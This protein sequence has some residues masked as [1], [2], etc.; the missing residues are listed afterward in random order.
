MSYAVQQG[1][2]D[3]IVVKG[4]I[5]VWCPYPSFPFFVT[6]VCDVRLCVISCDIN[7][8]HPMI[9]GTVVSY[10]SHIHRPLHG[11]HT[12]L[13]RTVFKASN[14]KISLTGLQ[15]QTRNCSVSLMR[16]L[17]LI[18]ST[19]TG[20]L[21]ILRFIIRILLRAVTMY[22]E[23]AAIAFKEAVDGKV[24]E[25]SSVTELQTDIK[26]HPVSPPLPPTPPPLGKII[27]HC[28]RHGFVRPLSNSEVNSP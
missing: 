1:L 3:A 7:H 11:S 19:L 13:S 22:L 26:A 20:F 23:T 8:L 17:T 14:S 2:I 9:A 12:P 25:A 28:I 10:R 18:T 15:K 21:R 6:W 16:L 5:Y 24:T 27:V 4:S